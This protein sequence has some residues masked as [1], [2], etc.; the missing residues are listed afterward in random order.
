MKPEDE[1]TLYELYCS[2][3]LVPPLTPL[4]ALDKWNDH[5]SLTASELGET[6]VTKALSQIL[7]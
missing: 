7:L 4:S 6:P 1:K 5:P 3:K 2:M